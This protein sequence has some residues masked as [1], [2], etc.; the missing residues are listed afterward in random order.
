MWPSVTVRRACV[1]LLA[2]SALGWAATQAGS[3]SSNLTIASVAVESQSVRVTVVNSGSVTRS[4]DITIRMTLADGTKVGAKR[5][6]TVFGR[7]KA[8]VHF[9]MPAVGTFNDVT[10]AGSIIDDPSPF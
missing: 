7:Q 2:C 5:S 4:A 8:F 1:A 6:V 10:I 3:K 9:S